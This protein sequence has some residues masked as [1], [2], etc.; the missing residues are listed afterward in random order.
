MA[1]FPRSGII[2]LLTDFGLKDSYVAEMKGVI[3]SLAPGMTLID[4]THLVPP[5]DITRAAFVLASTFQRFPEG[6]V[7]LAVVDPDVGTER[8]PIAVEATGHLFVA[9]D[10]GLLSLAL[11]KAGDAKAVHLT[12]PR[13]WLPDV[14]PTFHGRDIFAPVAADLARGELLETLG[15]SISSWATLPIEPPSPLGG[16]GVRGKVMAIDH[17]GNIV[18]NIREFDLPKDAQYGHVEIRLSGRKIEGISRTYGDSPEG[19]L[20]ALVGSSGYLEIAMVNGN[21][22]TELSGIRSG[23]EVTVR[24]FTESPQKLR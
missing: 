18:T 11:G 3:L 9:P 20:V 19:D 1:S 22:A 2:T 5:Q 8:R 17:F 16:D 14:S 6:T 23:A 15:T 24:R 21:A 7:H 4:V 12:E 10:N 13:F